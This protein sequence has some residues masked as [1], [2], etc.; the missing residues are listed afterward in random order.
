M[1]LISVVEMH[2]MRDLDR[3]NEVESDDMFPGNE[4]LINV[5]KVSANSSS[6]KYLRRCGV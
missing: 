3:E 6:L 2:C 1:F 5:P 4:C